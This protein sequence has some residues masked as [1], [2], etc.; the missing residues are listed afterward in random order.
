MSDEIERIPLRFPEHFSWHAVAAVMAERFGWRGLRGAAMIAAMVGYFVWKGCA[1]PL[2]MVMYAVVGTGAVLAFV[3]LW[4][5]KE[6][7]DKFITAHRSESWLTVDDAGV[8]GESGAQK[9]HIPWQQFRRVRNRKDMWLMET[10]QGGW[11]VVP[12][13]DFTARAWTLFRTQ[14]TSPGTVRK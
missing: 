10:R 12:T 8:G 1:S 5:A 3:V 13:R 2:C 14:T 11:L 9:F 7:L 6:S 4:V